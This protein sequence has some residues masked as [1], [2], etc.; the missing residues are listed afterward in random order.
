MNRHGSALALAASACRHP[1]RFVTP[2]SPT[3]VVANH[4]E[5]RRRRRVGP[6]AS[7][8]SVGVSEGVTAL[9]RP[10]V[11]FT[12]R[13]SGRP[14][15]SFLAIEAAAGGVASSD[16]SR[17]RRE[18]L[19]VN[20]VESKPSSLSKPPTTATPSKRGRATKAPPARHD[21]AARRDQLRRL[22]I[23]PLRGRGRGLKGRPGRPG[24][25]L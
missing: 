14:R 22:T 1:R 5:M 20:L 9:P 21:R 24:G 7:T 3:L 11:R 17:G 15:S 4:D 23:R 12:V 6:S 8:V 13:R 18:S 19:L 2:P 25:F 16:C 10:V